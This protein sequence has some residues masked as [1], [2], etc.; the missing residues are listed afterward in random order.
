MIEINPSLFK[1][2]PFD[3]QLDGVKRLVTQPAFALFD[4]MG[5]GKSKQIVDAACVLREAGEIDCVLVMAPA[6]CKSVWLNEEYGQIKTHAW[7]PSVVASY[8]RQSHVQWVTENAPASSTLPWIV[9]NYEYL[10]ALED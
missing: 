9:T 7:A 10:R 1:T 8:H 4:E 6:S 3:H 2:R 5:S